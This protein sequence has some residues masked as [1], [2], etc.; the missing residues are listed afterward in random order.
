MEFLSVRW[1]HTEWSTW[2]SSSNLPSLTTWNCRP[3]SDKHNTV[4]DFSF[5]RYH[6]WLSV[7]CFDVDYKFVWNLYLD[8]K[9]MQCLILVHV[10]YA[11]VLTFSWL[12]SFKSWWIKL[13]MSDID[14]FISKT[15]KYIVQNS[16]ESLFQVGKSVNVCSNNGKMF[17]TVASYCVLPINNPVSVAEQNYIFHCKWLV[18]IEIIYM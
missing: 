4:P 16:H 14:R 7:L 12:F 10:E 17:W 13:F 3:A 9:L 2:L 11:T 1:R 5:A 18:K 8:P 6:T 15:N